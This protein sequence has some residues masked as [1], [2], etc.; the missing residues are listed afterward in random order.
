MNVYFIALSSVNMLFSKTGLVIAPFIKNLQVLLVYFNGVVSVWLPVTTMSCSYS[1]AYFYWKPDLLLVK[2]SSDV[3]Q[4]AHK[5]EGK[6]LN[7]GYI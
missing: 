1:Y 5:K 2:S 4:I 6:K 7:A 3:D